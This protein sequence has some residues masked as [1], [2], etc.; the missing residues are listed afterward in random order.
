MDDRGMSDSVA[1][2][3]N[4][5]PPA[6]SEK[7]RQL[8]GLPPTGCSP[9]P[10]I[11]VA[12]PPGV[13]RFALTGRYS[14]PKRNAHQQNKS[15][16]TDHTSGCDS[17]L[18]LR[19]PAVETPHRPSQQQLRRSPTLHRGDWLGRAEIRKSKS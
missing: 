6:P 19:W 10:Q 8:M 13:L 4:N 11:K 5:D 16:T 12:V 14:D 7:A 9:S 1:L 3:K 17:R 18:T 15:P 2:M